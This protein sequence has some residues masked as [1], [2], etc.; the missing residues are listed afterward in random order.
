M[1]AA[2]RRVALN[3]EFGSLLPVLREHIFREGYVVKP[4]VEN[5]DT[6]MGISSKNP[7]EE[8]GDDVSNY[9][10]ALHQ[11]PAFVNPFEGQDIE[12]Y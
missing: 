9:L 8:Q 6:T 11:M 5:A 10:H 7:L 1:H 12:N 4:L 3:K 2:A